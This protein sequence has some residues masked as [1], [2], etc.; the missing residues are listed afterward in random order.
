MGGNIY[1]VAGKTQ[2]G[3]TVKIAGRETFAAAD[4]S[5][6]LQISS[7]SAEAKV[8]ISDER[9]NRSGFVISLR[10]ARVVRRY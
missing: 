4:G 1:R 9:G 2:S 5:F 8:D 3:A 10:N 7:P 6:I